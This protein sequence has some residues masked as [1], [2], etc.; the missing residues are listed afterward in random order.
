MQSSTFSFFFKFLI[1][2][3]CRSTSQ[4]PFFFLS[5]GQEFYWDV[6]ACSSLAVL[7]VIWVEWNLF[8]R[9]F[10]R[11]CSL[12]FNFL[13]LLDFVYVLFSPIP[14][15]WMSEVMESV[16]CSFASAHLLPFLEF[17]AWTFCVH[18][19]V[20]LWKTWFWGASF[21]LFLSEGPG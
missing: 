19:R 14:F 20:T 4:A 15:W 11:N 12:L 17:E 10:C 2:S 9:N 7:V 21:I 1:S 18:F 3:G 8:L 16:C 5:F 6:H 13:C